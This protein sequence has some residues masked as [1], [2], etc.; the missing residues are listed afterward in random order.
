MI[1]KDLPSLRY[2]NTKVIYSSDRT[3]SYANS[4][5][6]EI[7]SLLSTTLLSPNLLTAI[8]PIATNKSLPAPKAS[9]EM[10]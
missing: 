7:K 9:V 2:R 1:I 5:H 6:M 8:L 4:S 3:F 10:E